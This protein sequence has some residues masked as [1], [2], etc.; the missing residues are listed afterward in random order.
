MLNFAEKYFNSIN[1]KPCALNF[2]LVTKAALN[3]FFTSH[4][5]PSAMQNAKKKHRK[6]G[7]KVSGVTGV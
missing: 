3:L 1:S 4:G 2:M 7:E 6:E 5:A